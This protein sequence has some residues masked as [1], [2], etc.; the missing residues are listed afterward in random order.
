[1]PICIHCR[2]AAAGTGPIVR[3]CLIC[4]AP[5]VGVYTDAVPLNEQRVVRHKR[6][7]TGGSKIWCEGS[8]APP[9]LKDGHDYCDGCPCQ[10]RPKGSWNQRP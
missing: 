8:L 5:G 10:H 7:I 4:G 1:M 9:V 6:E 2:K 3:H